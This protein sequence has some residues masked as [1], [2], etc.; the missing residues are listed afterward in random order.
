MIRDV[1]VAELDGQSGLGYRDEHG[2]LGIVV[3]EP[4]ALP[5]RY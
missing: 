2:A 4:D 3:A 1:A 5:R